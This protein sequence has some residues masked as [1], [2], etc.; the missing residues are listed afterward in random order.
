MAIA[1]GSES[2][3]EALDKKQRDLILFETRR[4]RFASGKVVHAQDP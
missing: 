1:I 3:G 2:S 4:I